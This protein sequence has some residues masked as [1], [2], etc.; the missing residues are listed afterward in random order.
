V[1]GLSK[2]AE[3]VNIKPHVDRFT[4]PNGNGVIVLALGRLAHV[5]ADGAQPSFALSV[6]FT[7]QVRGGG[8]WCVGGVPWLLYSY[9]VDLRLHALTCG[10]E[11]M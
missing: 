9:T 1:Q 4:L 10:S 11:P 6:E 8:V 7:L 5:A 2:L 3:R